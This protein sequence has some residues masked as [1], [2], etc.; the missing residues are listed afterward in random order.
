M[1]LLCVKW[2]DSCPVIAASNFFGI[3]PVQK[4]ER[5]VERERKRLI[6]QPFIIKVYNEGMDGLDVSDRLLSSYRPRLRSKKW[7]WNLFSNL[8]NLSVVALFR[9][10]NFVNQTNV[11]HLKFCRKIATSLV[12]SEKADCTWE[13]L[14]HSPVLPSALMEKTI[15][16]CN[17]SGK[18]C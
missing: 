11:T 2:N 1:E 18:M 9:F 14:L 6:D 16:E 10:Y 7:W 8:L 3:S 15:S 12:R 17:K 5:T 13:D 4:A